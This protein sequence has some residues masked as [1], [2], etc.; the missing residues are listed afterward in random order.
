MTTITWEAIDHIFRETTAK[1]DEICGI[2]ADD[3]EAARC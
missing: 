3:T 1:T 2:T